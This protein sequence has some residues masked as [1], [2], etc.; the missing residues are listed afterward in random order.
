MDNMRVLEIAT[1]AVVL[2]TLVSD[3]TCAAGT[4]SARTGSAPVTVHRHDNFAGRTGT[5]GWR[6]G[7]AN[8]RSI[9][10]LGRRQPGL[11][12]GSEYVPPY[13]TDLD[14]ACELQRVQIS[15]DY[16]WR[17]RSIVVCPP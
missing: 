14:P 12:Y 7:V 6:G 13:G 17:V 5:V 8:H 16:G 3:V 10:V 4:V 9:T 15:D 11:G 2:S 1:I